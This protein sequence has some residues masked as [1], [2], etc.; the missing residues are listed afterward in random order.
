MSMTVPT[1]TL[2]TVCKLRWVPKTPT[3]QMTITN[4]E[5]LRLMATA[6]LLEQE[7]KWSEASAAEM[8][9][10]EI[11]ELENREYL[12]G[13]KHTVAVTSDASW[14]MSDLGTPL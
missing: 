6:I 4:L 8:K 10:R 9:A 1:S 11:L 3:Q 13:I 5:A 7:E 12:K 2:L 14:S